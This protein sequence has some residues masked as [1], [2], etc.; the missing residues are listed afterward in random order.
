MNKYRNQKTI[1]DGVTFDSKAEAVRY[2]ELK[3][4]YKAG[5]IHDL[6]Y[7]FIFKLEVNKIHVCNY[8]ADFAYMEKG[9]CVVE[10][11]KGMKTAVYQLKKK[12]LFASRGI[13]VTEIG[14]KPKAPRKA[15]KATPPQGK[16]E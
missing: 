2:S 13:T 10:D 11:V 14:V 6:Q 5:M 9:K 1:V 8:I 4:L 7:Q 15:R 16:P 3:L 12:L